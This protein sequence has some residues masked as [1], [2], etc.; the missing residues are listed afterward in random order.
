MKI[1]LFFLFQKALLGS[2]LI[3]NQNSN[4]CNSFLQAITT[5]LSDSNNNKGIALLWSHLFRSSY[6]GKDK[7]KLF[8][9]VH[10]YIVL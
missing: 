1:F 5:S 7:L 2:L 10:M 4:K 6:D 9:N 8:Q 3:Q